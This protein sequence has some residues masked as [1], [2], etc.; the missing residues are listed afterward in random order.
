[1]N[2][3]GVSEPINLTRLSSLENYIRSTILGQEHVLSRITSALL[4]GELGLR[5]INRPRASFLLLGPTGVGKTEIT[6]AFTHYLYGPERLFRFD[7]SEYQTMESLSHLLGTLNTEGSLAKVCDNHNKGTLLFD[8]IE[9]AHPRILDI[10]LQIL[11]AA[12]VTTASGKTLY[13]SGFTIVFT[14]NIASAELLDLQHS[15]FATME[16]HVLTR[17]Q[18]QMRPE[19]Y[20]RINEKLVFQKLSYEVLLEIAQQ[21]LTQELAFLATKGHILTPTG[22]TLNFLV[23]HGYH[24]RLGARPMRDAVERL[25]GEA[26]VSSLLSGG[27]GCG[28][29]DLDPS[30]ARLQVIPVKAVPF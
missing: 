22:R 18:Q 17:A 8:E 19:L 11:D 15:T 6:V 4:R 23:K 12:R 14:S 5:K 24:P 1:M 30:A 2:N 13:L 10:F 25:L 3:P 21:L 28:V 9:K 29:V 27:T 7:M 26:I 20:A 16:R